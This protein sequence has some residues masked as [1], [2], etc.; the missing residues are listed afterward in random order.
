[1]MSQYDEGLQLLQVKSLVFE[2]SRRFNAKQMGLTTHIQSK[3]AHEALLSRQ[4]AELRLLETM[5]RCITNKI[6]SDK[7]YAL[8]LTAV[9]LQGQKNDRVE[10]LQS[11]TVAS[12]WKGMMGELEAA[13]KLVKTNAELVEKETLEKLNTLCQE[14]R[15][16]RKSYLEEYNRITQQFTNVSTH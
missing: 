7:D 14:K 1:M 10:E 4:D 12:A 15:K 2:L 6:K 5:R 3:A 13:A 8:A 9:A 11:S 16:A